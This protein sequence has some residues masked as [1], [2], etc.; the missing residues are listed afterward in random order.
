M[1]KTSISK[2][3]LVGKQIDYSFSKQYFATKF[4]KEGIEASQYDNY[5]ITA[6]EDFPLIL[7]NNPN[8]KGL[9]VTIPYKETILE[10]LDEVSPTVQKIGAVNTIKITKNKKLIGYNTDIYGFELA[11]KLKLKKIHQKALILGSGG[12]AKAVKFVFEKL[13][14]PFLVVSRNPTKE[15]LHYSKIDEALLLSYQLIVNTTPLGTF[16]NVDFAPAIPYQYLT[17]QHYLFD[18]VY[19]PSK[20]LFLVQ[21]EKQGA[22]IQ[23]GLKM[24]EFQ[25]EKAWEI[26]NK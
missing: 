16:P 19:N 7:K 11:L 22:S 25:A 6:I 17:K 12:A 24:L 14:I 2:Y 4:I 26:W 3:G 21:G 1:K 18:L 23:N 15:Q 5:P 10:Y 8:I 20:T 9:N 13:E